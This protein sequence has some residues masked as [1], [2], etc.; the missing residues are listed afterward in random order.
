MAL[1]RADPELKDLY[2]E[3]A[4]YHSGKTTGDNLVDSLGLAIFKPPQEPRRQSVVFP[5]GYNQQGG[6]QGYNRRHSSSCSW[7]RC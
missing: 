7:K 2:F 1:A 4:K 3:M 6:G 5:K